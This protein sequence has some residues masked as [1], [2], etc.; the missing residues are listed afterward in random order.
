MHVAENDLIEFLIDTGLASKKALLLAEEEAGKTSL[1]L[2]RVILM[3][4]LLSENDLR[5]AKSYIL[6][7]PFVDLRG[8]RFD[9]SLLSLIPEP[10]SREHNAVA[11]KRTGNQVEVAFLDLATLPEVKF[12]EGVHRVCI[13]PRLTD[14]ESL[15]HAL[16]SYRDGLKIEFGDV[17]GR[18]ARGLN[19]LKKDVDAHTDAELRALAD[20]GRTARIL[21]ALLT[22]ALLSKATNIHI[23][24]TEKDIRVRYRLGGTLHEAI[25][26]PRHLAPRLTLRTKLLSGMNLRDALPQDGRFAIDTSAGKSAFRVSTAPTHFGEKIMMRVLPESAAGFTLESLGM[27]GKALETLEKALGRKEGLI[28]ACGPSASGK[29]T[30]LYTVLD[31]LNSPEKNIHTVEDPIEYSM[32]RIHQTEVNTAKGLTLAR[33]L[34]GAAMQDADVLMISDIKDAESLKMASAASLSGELV[35]GGVFADSAA[36]G[37]VA[38]AEKADERKLFASALGASVG[39]RVVR[40]LGPEREKYFLSKEE[41]RT[42]GHLVSLDTLLDTMK[43]EGVVGPNAKWEEVGFYKPRK[44]QWAK[45]EYQGQIGLFEIVPATSRIKELVM[46]GAS[47]TSIMEESRASGNLTLIED[48]VIKAVLGLTTIEEVVR[49]VS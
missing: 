37:I 16:V 20:E 44:G 23:E 25:I 13:V 26:L 11:Y 32:H 33:A 36:D 49:A 47:R 38:F 45:L 29:S 6:G 17:I 30:F 15:K 35:L 12:V 8:E 18:E 21:G 9:L 41:L 48:G 2:E 43:H 42:L 34:R 31:I 39:M 19:E 27:R 46:N 24:P 7:V 5:R 28:L 40:K 14:T 22:H 4:G 1:A 10:I 3:H